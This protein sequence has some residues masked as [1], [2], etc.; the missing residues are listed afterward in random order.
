MICPECKHN[1]G[2]DVPMDW[3][4]EGWKHGDHKYIFLKNMTAEE[5]RDWEVART[6]TNLINGETE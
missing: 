2:E 5:V 4:G 1:Y 3:F 6:S